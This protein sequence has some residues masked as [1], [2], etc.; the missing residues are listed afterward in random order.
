MPAPT[1]EQIDYL[2]EISLGLLADPY[3]NAKRPILACSPIEHDFDGINNLEERAPTILLLCRNIYDVE[4]GMRNQFSVIHIHPDCIG[5]RGQARAVSGS[6][7]S[8]EVI[9]IIAAM[10]SIVSKRAWLL[11]VLGL[12]VSSYCS[13]THWLVCRKSSWAKLVDY[14][15]HETTGESIL[16]RADLYKRQLNKGNA[17]ERFKAIVSPNFQRSKLLWPLYTLTLGAWLTIFRRK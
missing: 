3:R 6:L 14:Y 9:G 16:V 4:F 13:I 10:I 5:L 15:V 12:G 8:M 7:R 1:Q 11:A 2:V 17:W